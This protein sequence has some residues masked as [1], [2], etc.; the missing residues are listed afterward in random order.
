MLSLQALPAFTDNYIWTLSDDAGKA[1]LVDPGQ[2]GP[3]LQAV[4]EG[5]IPI[6]ILL[7]HHHHDHIGGVGEL[8]D[9][10][11]IPC[12]APVDDR[13]ARAT[14]RVGE[15]DRIRI[16]PLDLE[17]DVLAVPGHT[18][19]HV[20]YHG[21]GFLFCGDTLFSLGC[22]RL[23]EGTPGQMLASLDR[24]AALPGDTLVCCGH[25]YTQSNGR[26]AVAAE[27]QNELRDLR[28]AEVAVLRSRGLPSVPSS[29]ASER[30]CNP[31]LRVDQPGIKRTLRSH[32]V[33]GDN[34]GQSFAALRAWKDRFAA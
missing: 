28:L 3:V 24:L 21:G 13:I 27:P 15:G 30:D 29:L 31:F 33:T 14:H 7:T 22:G 23:F 32:G 1:V 6:A 26:F 11:D 18:L 4:A 34:R 5:L 17:I 25:E 2:A 20:A 16:E 10:F 9:R 12:Y 19:S 8:L